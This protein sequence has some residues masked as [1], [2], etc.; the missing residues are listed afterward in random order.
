MRIIGSAIRFCRIK[1][2]VSF[3]RCAI[4]TGA[5]NALDGILHWH[6]S[7]LIA[8][9]VQAIP[10]LRF[11]QHLVCACLDIFPDICAGNLRPTLWVAFS[12]H[13]SPLLSRHLRRGPSIY[14]LRGISHAHISAE[15]PTSARPNLDTRFE[16]QPPCAHVRSM[17]RLGLLCD[18]DD[19]TDQCNRSFTPPMAPFRMTSPTNYKTK[20]IHPDG[21]IPLIGTTDSSAR[22]M[23]R[24]Q[25]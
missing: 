22:D 25:R 18:E 17:R 7:H 14:T 5:Q 10:V 23:A 2:S 11:W 6:I 8:T 12:L 20:G 19:R 16:W 21:Q 9:C 24:R 15:T 1:I 4:A 13:T 3:G